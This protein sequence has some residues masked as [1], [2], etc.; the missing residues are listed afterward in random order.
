M[1]AITPSDPKWNPTFWLMVARIKKRVMWSAG[2]K[3]N[4]D[5][6]KLNGGINQ[7]YLAQLYIYTCLPASLEQTSVVPNYIIPLH[8]HTKIY[9]CFHVEI[10]H[11][12][13][14]LF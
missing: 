4:M 8:P 1:F 10:T 3:N 12:P 5:M 7:L 9:C 14:T 13:S 11:I 6:T 2:K